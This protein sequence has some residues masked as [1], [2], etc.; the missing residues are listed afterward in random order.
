[1]I[2][3]PASCEIHTV[4]CFLLAKIMS[5]MEI[6]P[7]I[8]AVYGENVTSKGTGSQW[9]RMFKDGRENVYNEERSGQLVICSE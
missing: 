5:A 9:N 8:C 3:N 4:I 1:M 2:D 7:E 6:Q